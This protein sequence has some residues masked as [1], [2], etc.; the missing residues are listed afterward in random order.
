MER[1]WH[2][3]ITRVS[4]TVQAILCGLR[5]IFAHIRWSKYT[6]YLIQK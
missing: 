1:A 6:G 2:I 5:L 3:F 4:L